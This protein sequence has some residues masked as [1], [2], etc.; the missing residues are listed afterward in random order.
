VV[1]VGAERVHKVVEGK[2]KVKIKKNNKIKTNLN[3]KK[4]V[5]RFEGYCTR[6]HCFPKRKKEE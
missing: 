4:I 6:F 3:K 2:K 1:V 5:L